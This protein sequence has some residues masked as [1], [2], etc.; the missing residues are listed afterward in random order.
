M[1]ARRLKPTPLL[2]IRPDRERAP[3]FAR[4][5]VPAQL[6]ALAL[7]VFA[8]LLPLSPARSQDGGEG[9]PAGAEA[10]ELDPFEQLNRDYD[11]PV[12]RPKTE[13]GEGRTPNPGRATSEKPGQ[14]R[15]PSRG[16][17]SESPL[18]SS[19][20]RLSDEPVPLQLDDVPNRPTPLLELGSPFLG[21]GPISLGIELPTGSV[22]QPSVLIYGTFRS[23]INVWR[24]TFGRNRSGAEDFVEWANRFDLFANVQ[25]AGFNNERLVI[26]MRPLDEALYGKDF[27]GWRFE[28]TSEDGS[29]NEFNSRLS[30]LFFEGDLGEIL[31]FLDEE[32]SRALDIGFSVGRQELVFQSGV[33]INDIVDS[34]GITRNNAGVSWASNLRIT[35]LYGWNQIHRGNFQ[36]DDSAE[37]IGL[38]TS[39]DFGVTTID[40]DA[41]LTLAPRD[42]GDAF[43]AGVSA[44]QRLGGSINTTLRAN[45]SLPVDGDRNQTTNTRGG[46]LIFESSW[47]PTGTEDNLYVNAYVGIDRYM[48]AARSPSTGGP[49]ERVGILYTAIGLGR[50]P[51]ALNGF[52]ERS[53]GGGIG[54][55]WFFHTT[56]RQLIV[57]LGGR[58]ETT[59]TGPARGM[60][61]LGARF[62][63][64]FWQRFIF[65]VD[66]FGRLEEGLQE[67][68]GG[69]T[70]LT[71]RF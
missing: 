41:A 52:P 11:Q 61:A 35:A 5:P 34:V 8:L 37:L 60:L 16:T 18:D 43:H 19:P 24:E 14:T 2:S 55:Q 6:G 29:V 9:E 45:V 23:G 36:R 70:E 49:L 17:G 21:N 50:F 56:T 51:S 27:T 10:R 4:R 15:P 31:P 71:I 68:W 28:P 65:R 25:L 32:D 44:T 48:S 39:T 67:A 3:G 54:Y 59:S 12:E 69:H 40:L 22:W 38:F 63:Q 7:L 13:P 47:T 30:A 66:G 62:Q 1:V 33:M 58:K 42:T 20:S 53:V 26:G 46:L 64:A 57:E